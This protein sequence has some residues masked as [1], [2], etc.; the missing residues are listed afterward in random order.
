MMT[1]LVSQLNFQL[2][3][4]MKV[5]WDMNRSIIIILVTSHNYKLL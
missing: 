5:Y 4:E 2:S 3:A 1:Y